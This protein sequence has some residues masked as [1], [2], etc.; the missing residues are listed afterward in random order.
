[1][2]DVAAAAVEAVHQAAG[3]VVAAAGA[4][5]RLAGGGGHRALFVNVTLYSL[6]YRH[7]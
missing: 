6:I 7:I 4:G 5:S 3:A 1:M 2:V